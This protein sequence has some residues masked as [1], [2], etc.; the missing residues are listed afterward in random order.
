MLTDQS[1]TVRELFRRSEPVLALAPMQDVTDHPFWS[2]LASYDGPDLYYTE[3]FRVHSVSKLDKYILR[4]ITENPTGRPVVAQILG[5]DISSL[6]RAARQ[7]EQYPIA[8]VDLNLGCPAPIVCRKVAGG[9]LLRDLGHIDA[10]L[11]ALREAVATS[12]SVKT[13]LGYESAAGFGELLG[14]LGRHRLD[15]VVVHG[16]AV[17]ES[18]RQPVH[19]D[20][21]AQAARSLPC[22]VI[23]N[24]DIFT[25]PQALAVLRRTGVR[26]LMIGR[27]AIRNPWIFRQIRQALRGAPV[28]L[29]RGREVLGYVRSLYE[30]V[31]PAGIPERKHIEKMKL[32]M[33]HL[34][35]GV[36][37]EGRFLH[38][39]RRVASE[40]EFFRVCETYLDHDHFLAL[41]HHSGAGEK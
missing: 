38:Q 29:P 8:G 16:R 2:L 23:A 6:T 24:G 30:A 34:A 17:K 31:R 21:I 32:Y 19:Y 41:D 13:R 22:P 7:L 4:S 14:L 39:I 9:G 28:T 5:H 11:H 25:A 35:P 36:E 27:G 33:I 12:L 3:Y 1:Q 40:A 18:F 20:E 37:P 26:G 10:I 15:L